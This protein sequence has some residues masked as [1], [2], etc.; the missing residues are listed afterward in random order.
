MTLKKAYVLKENFDFFWTI[1]P[2]WT[3]YKTNKDIDFYTPTIITEWKIPVLSPNLTLHFTNIV[4]SDY[5][6]LVYI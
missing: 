6:V 5:F 1:I 2:K 4:V 3:V